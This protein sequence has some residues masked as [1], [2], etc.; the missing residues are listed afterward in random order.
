MTKLRQWIR[1][2]L[3]RLLILSNNENF[4]DQNFI[5]MNSPINRMSSVCF[6]ISS[7]IMTFILP[8]FIFLIVIL[9]TVVLVNDINDWVK[10]MFILI[11]LFNI[12]IYKIF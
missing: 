9:E 2:E 7:D 3:V 5:K 8:T 11:L 6:M 1:N 4:S 10:P 12:I